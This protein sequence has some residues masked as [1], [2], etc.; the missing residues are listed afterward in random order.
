[1]SAYHKNA[2]PVGYQ[3]GEYTFESV[4]GHGGFGIT[5]LAQDTALGAQVAIKE[6]LPHQFALRDSKTGVVLPNPS[7]DAVRD[8][9]W[10]LKNFVKEARALAQ[11]KHPHIVRVLRFLEANGTAYMVMEYEKGESLSQNLKHNGPRLD[12]TQ[13]LRVFIPILNGLHA[14]HE[15]NM[16]HLDIKPE[17][18]Y[19]RADGSPMLIDFGSA[20]QAIIDTGH[21]DRVALTHGFAPV[22]QYPDKGKPGPWT[23]V[24]AVGATMYRCVTG[25]RP[26]SALD[27][28]Q[29]QLKYQVDPMQSASQLVKKRYSPNLLS[30]VDWAMQVQPK[31]RPQ[32]ARELQDALMGKRAGR[33]S[34]STSVPVGSRPQTLNRPAVYPSKRA[35]PKTHHP[36]LKSYI[37]LLVIVI[38]LLA[39]VGYWFYAR[40]LI[41]ADRLPGFLPGAGQSQPAAESPPEI[42][43]R[44]DAGPG[45]DTGARRIT[46]KPA[47][48]P[49]L[50]GREPEA[51]APSSLPTTLVYTLKG[52]TDWVLTLAFSPSSRWLATAGQDRTIQVWDTR[53]GKLT[54]TLRGQNAVIH[55]IAFSPDGK[56]IASA[57]LDGSVRFWDFASNRQIG[58]VRGPGG[59]LYGL[60]FSPDGKTIAAGGRDR[61][62]HVWSLS[63]G[64]R[65]YALEGHAGDIN[66]V[67]YSPDSRW[68]VSTST[69]K[70]ARVWDMSNGGLHATL[71]GHRDRVM[72]LSF[73]AD[74]KWLVTGDA[75]ST[76]RL[77]D[78]TDF[79]FQRNIGDVPGAILSLSMS[80]DGRWLA[81]G[82]SGTS[83]YLVDMANGSITRT[84]HGHD[85][86]VQA[87][88]YS[89]DG[90]RLAT[91]GRDR[92]VRFWTAR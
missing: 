55:A 60:A 1:V 47:V 14:V 30:C 32:S 25:K 59:P 68:L 13:L 36:A 48:V 37:L 15:A 52:H 10:G 66:A 89:P 42:G 75:R 90:Q 27:R 38:L 34:G 73:S 82:T 29:A 81:V 45:D 11:F 78:A 84:L 80:P 61:S 4:L 43:G 88:S 18:I 40:L 83:A 72:A 6:Y 46:A 12:E 35:V 2:L 54:G 91:G 26:D 16:L 67:A 5:Y 65:L 69:D 17:N 58:G 71:G 24:Y 7:R 33:P 8:Y 9:H 76:I 77:W 87:V 19:L 74:G 57:G 21:A 85:D 62:I 50:P 22:E 64:N 92:T 53:S 23:D 56:Q 20:R 39:G 49:A 28:Y 44:R 79:S 41:P 51:I 86:Y 70:T 31:D 63:S 3:L